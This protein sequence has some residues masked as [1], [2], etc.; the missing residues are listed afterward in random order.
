VAT[1]SWRGASDERALFTEAFVDHAPRLYQYLARQLS[2]T[3]AEDV[4]AET[5][6][7]AWQHRARYLEVR[8]PMVGWLFGIATN[9]LKRHKRSWL[10]G[11]AAV[12]RLPIETGADHADEVVRRV[13]AEVTSRLL[14]DALASLDAR[15][16]E[17]LLLSSWAQLDHAEIA[18]ALDIPV[19]TVR[20]RLHRARHRLLTR[21]TPTLDDTGD[22]HV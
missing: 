7:T 2:P 16:R 20:S 1:R 21:L 11:A 6:C 12:R 19:G 8:G 17:V 4:L 13:D 3:E 15:D 14:A 5:F 9:L 10:R 22:R 18:T